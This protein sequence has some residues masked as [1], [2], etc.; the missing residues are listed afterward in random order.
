DAA[1]RGRPS[2]TSSSTSQGVPRG[3]ATPLGEVNWTGRVPTKLWRDS[4]NGTSAPREVVGEGTHIAAWRVSTIR[5]SDSHQQ[6]VILI[7]QGGIRRQVVHEEA[8]DLP[9]ARSVSNQAVP[10][11]H[12]TGVRAGSSRQSPPRSLRSQA[13]PPAVSEARSETSASGSRRTGSAESP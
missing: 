4:W 8:L 2:R 3:P 1:P 9:I 12:S 7:E 11:K 6:R 10:L 5:F 13:I